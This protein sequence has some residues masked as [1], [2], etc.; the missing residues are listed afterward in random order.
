MNGA[1]N[2]PTMVEQIRRIR[3][4]DGRTGLLLRR[5]LHRLFDLGYVT[6]SPDY[7]FRVGECLRDEFNNGH[8]YY[9]LSGS[10]ITVLGSESSQPDR[11]FLDR[12]SREVFKG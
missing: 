4:G 3:G 2:F 6:I 10:K 12:H 1:P 8:S 11:E 7:V 5:D 9:G